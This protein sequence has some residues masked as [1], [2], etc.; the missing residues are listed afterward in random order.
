MQQQ[1]EDELWHRQGMGRLGSGFVASFISPWGRDLSP[2]PRINRFALKWTAWGADDEG[3]RDAHARFYALSTS[4]TIS[5]TPR[6]HMYGLM[7]PLWLVLE[8]CMTHDTITVHPSER[9]SF[10]KCCDFTAATLSDG[11]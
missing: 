6:D 10:W 9:R 11:D 4:P 1:H 3:E 5:G 2:W 8:L 7:Q